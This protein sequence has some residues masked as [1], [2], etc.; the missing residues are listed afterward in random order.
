MKFP[1]DVQFSCCSN[2]LVGL[3]DHDR[4]PKE[5]AWN[6]V[7]VQVP[8]KGGSGTSHDMTDVLNAREG[9]VL[10]EEVQV[11]ED[12]NACSSQDEGDAFSVHYPP[13][14]PES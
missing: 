14:L 8:L 2:V 6:R 9:V 12:G 7:D 13:S 3:K 1:S 11:V 4:V 5:M 10:K